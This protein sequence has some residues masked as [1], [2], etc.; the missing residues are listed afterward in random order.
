MGKQ[1]FGF[2]FG[3]KKQKPPRE[4][5]QDMMPFVPEFADEIRKIMR[6]D[7]AARAG[8][9]VMPATDGDY[10]GRVYDFFT[11]RGSSTPN[12]GFTQVGA[13]G[14]PGVYTQYT[15]GGQWT[16]Q[17]DAMGAV[18][19]PTIVSGVV[20]KA[21]PQVKVKPIEVLDKLGRIPEPV[22]MEELDTQ[23]ATFEDKTNLTNQHWAKQQM[24]A[25]VQCLK[26]RKKYP[27][28]IEFF[29]KFPYTTD[30]KIS[31]LVTTYKLVIRSADLFVPTL[32]KEAIDIMKEYKETCKKISG[33]EPNFYVIAE[34]QDF[35]DKYKKNDPIL[36]VQS[37]FGFFWQILGA[38]DKELLILSEL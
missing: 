21:D 19:A 29:S 18:E 24:Q 34:E 16:A 6:E 17:V 32:P 7:A 38:W 30:E 22:K 35:K 9:G 23:I 26:N 27:D 36:L 28:H 14:N 2:W 8:A 15:T 20:K 4:L 11:N 37:I 3:S 33:T 25:M 13:G 12:D 10:M 1:I 31:A 5:L